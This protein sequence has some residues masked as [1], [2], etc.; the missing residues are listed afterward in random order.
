L[1]IRTLHIVLFCILVI[2]S[3]GME[4]VVSAESIPVTSI[5]NSKKESLKTIFDSSQRVE[6]ILKLTFG[7][8]LLRDGFI[9]YLEEGNLLLPLEEIM[10]TLEFSIDVNP[11]EG[12]AIGWFLRE[13]RRFFLDVSQG[14][15]IVEGK[16]RKFLRENIFIRDGDI[17]VK[18]QLL[19]SW[20][21]INFKFDISALQVEIIAEEKLPFEEQLDREN[22][23]AQL[24][25]GG[26]GR[27]IF[28][29]KE[30]PYRL[31]NWPAI[32][33]SYNYNYNNEID[34][35]GL[36]YSNLISGDFLF[37]NTE[38]FVTGNREDKFS[39]LRLKMGRKDPDGDLFGISEF[40]MGDIF[41]PQIPLIADSQAGAGVEISSF[42]LFREAEF[43]RINLRGDLQFGW[44]VELYRN[45]VLLNAQAI[46]NADGRYEFLDVPLLFGSNI[47]RLVFYGPQGQRRE[48]IKRLN[49]G[50]NQAPP[51]K[52]YFY[53]STTL[54]NQD[55]FD[56]RDDD[57]KSTPI[58]G[59]GQARYVFEYQRGITRWFSL[60]G[61]FV[62]LPSKKGRQYF[63]TLGIRS[64]MFGASTRLDV[65]K[66]DTGG[67]AFEA[68]T[69][70]K[71]MGLNI[72]LEHSR[73][74]DF[75]SERENNL[76]DPVIH[77]SKTRLDSSL[78]SLGF[79]PRISWS[80]TGELEKSKS[81]LKR[82]DLSNRLSLSLFRI[83]VSNS[84][85]WFLVRGGESDSITTGTGSFQLSGR[86]NKL[87]LRSA[88]N[89]GIKP[90]YE[91]TSTTITGD[92][93]LNRDFS[94]KLGMNRQLNK[95]KLT[96]YN[97]GL[98][99]R[100]KSF[101]IG[102]NGNYSDDE[103][104]SIGSSLTF[105]F[106]REPRRKHWVARS[107]RLAS[108]GSASAQVFLDNNNNQLFDGG[109]EP[110][111]DVTF[112]SGGR[113]RKTDENGI[114]FLTGLSSNRPTPV[115]LDRVSLEDPFWVPAQ[116]GYEVVARPG[117]PLLLDFPITPTG[118]IDGTIYLASGGTEK[119]VSNAQMQ[120]VAADGEVIQEVKSEFDGFYLFQMV[121][122]G[123]YFVRIAPE[124][125]KRLK[126]K[127]PK[128]Q[129]V[130]ITGTEIVV[131]G[132]DFL[133][134]R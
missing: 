114:A 72:F 81:G 98:N 7:R 104:F 82:I 99:R 90:D 128:S 2:F 83:S 28:P 31:F 63:S 5:E 125:I 44:E 20:F 30:T 75:E 74:F 12:T 62:S 120:L 4:K 1:S 77:R 107:D 40:S 78:P 29:R 130:I 88:L 26:I 22:R 89:Y 58:K 129:E 112:R 25:K 61:N 86:L 21:P 68:A 65:T 96:T 46:P 23:R 51:G 60:A 11:N 109:D 53:F 57:A 18:S 94:I 97:A 41:S 35:F 84:S 32:D 113:E 93:R 24:N 79:I 116:E 111:K 101:S 131:S 110:L 121:P 55:L 124:Q 64:G 91:F 134:K 127:N 47:I 105:S 108:T 133:L 17:F 54:Q 19:A 69:L 66:N 16:K 126:L 56:V 59:D 122:L 106:G 118:E 115:V 70:T 71:I 37:M 87:Y 52:Q 100:F 49:V 117:A 14:E 43:D 132:T 36:D 92:Y 102:I 6:L 103:T 123:R 76:F 45:E 27:K 95:N 48:K 8:Y 73:F 42:P 119:A 34:G 39:Q 67:T 33:S 38:V 15:V 13:N 9:G 10:N 50:E 85:N 80:V 3:A